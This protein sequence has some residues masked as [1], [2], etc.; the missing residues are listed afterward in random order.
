MDVC[1]C[2]VEPCF[3]GLPAVTGLS[4]AKAEQESQEQMPSDS[5]WPDKGQLKNNEL[6]LRDVWERG[7]W[8]W[9]QA[10]SAVNGVTDHLLS[11]WT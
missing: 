7:A 8:P 11:T 9:P 1:G 5:R 4:R 3:V 6:S 2:M 10:V